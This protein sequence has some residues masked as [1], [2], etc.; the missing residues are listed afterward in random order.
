MIISRHVRSLSAVAVLAFSLV[1]FG[2]VGECFG[3][4]AAQKAPSKSVEGAVFAKPPHDELAH[5]THP[6]LRMELLRMA[7]EDQIVRSSGT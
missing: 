4:D 1:W 7:H 2:F 6:Q 3:Q 5:I